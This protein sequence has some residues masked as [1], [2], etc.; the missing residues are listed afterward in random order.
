MN[1]KKFSRKRPEAAQFSRRF[2]YRASEALRDAVADTIDAVVCPLADSD[3]SA[4]FSIAVEGS[5]L[6]IR[7]GKKEIQRLSV[8]SK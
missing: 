1:N 6:I 8:R 2:S 4:E 3:P 5:S 7:Q